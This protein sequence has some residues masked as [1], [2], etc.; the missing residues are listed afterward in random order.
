MSVH[1]EINH[2]LDMLMETLDE[3]VLLCLDCEHAYKRK[4]D[5]DMLFCRLRKRK[6]PKKKPKMAEGKKR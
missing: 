5:A 4:S 6:C 3:W 1:D 2:E